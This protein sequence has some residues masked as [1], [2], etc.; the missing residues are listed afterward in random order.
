MR[1]FVPMQISKNLVATIEYELTDD[2][3]EVIDTSKGGPPLAYLHGAGNLIPGLEAELEG[4]GSGDSFKVRIDPENAYGP[5]HDELVQ[6]VPRSQFPEEADIQPGMQFQAQV[7]EGVQIVTVVG[8]E[9]ENVMLDG[10]HPLAGVHLNFEVTIVEVREATA[11]ELEHGHVHGAGG[12]E[13]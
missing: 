4:K 11:E 13:H 5:R 7:P 1:N 6:G 9:G 8:I 12:H 2:G 3:G 10:N